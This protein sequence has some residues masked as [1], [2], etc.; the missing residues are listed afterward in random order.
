LRRHA[1]A[2]SA[3]PMLMLKAVFRR[4]FEQNLRQ[5]GTC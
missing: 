3:R 4:V 5:G 1:F 2:C